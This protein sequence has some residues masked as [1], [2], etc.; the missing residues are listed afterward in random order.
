MSRAGLRTP[1]TPVAGLV[2]LVVVL[3]LGMYAYDHARAEEIAKGVRIDGIDVGGMSRAAAAARVQRL[4]AASMERPVT[5]TLNGRGWQIIPRQAG[6]TVDVATTVDEA[7][8]ASRSG[9]IFSRTW[10]AVAGESVNRDLALRVRYSHRSIREFTA[11]V[12]TAVDQPPRNASVQPTASGLVE[13]KDSPGLT[14]DSHTLT[15]RVERALTGA[16][17]SR[18]L[19]VPVRTARAQV[20]SSELAAQNPA[21]IV[22]DRASFQL[23]FY[24]HLKLADTYPIAVGMEGLETPAGLYHIQWEQ[25]NPP[26]YVPKDSWAG[27]LAGKTI[28]PGPQDPLKARFMAFDGGAGIHGIDPSEYGTIGHDASHGCVRMRIPDVIALYARSPVGTPVYV[29]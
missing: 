9:S 27:A 24:G 15:D 11:R 29:L 5:A 23:R 20:T 25:V 1:L 7:V 18:G 16:T 3:L 10:R 21:Y 14:V 6:L 22:V 2:G 12:R 19:T 13:V 4:V 28:P 8:K 26:W 17:A